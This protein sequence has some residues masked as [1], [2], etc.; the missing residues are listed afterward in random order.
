MRLWGVGTVKIEHKVTHEENDVGSYLKKKR[1]SVN[2]G[3]EILQSISTNINLTVS[4]KPFSNKTEGVKAVG[5]CRLARFH[6]ISVMDTHLGFRT[7][8]TTNE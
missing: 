2:C 4:N 8:L 5:V 1:I 6:I 3:S 7:I